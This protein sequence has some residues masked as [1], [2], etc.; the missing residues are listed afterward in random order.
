[1]KKRLIEQTVI[2]FSILK[3]I[4]LAT[5][6]GAIVGVSTTIFLK[7]LHLSIDTT[8]NY[9]LTFL[10][11]PFAFFTSVI[12]TKYLAPDAEG[13]GTEKVIEAIHKNHGKMNIMVVPVKLVSTIISIASGGS[14]G[15]EG[16]CAQIGAGLASTFSDIFRF[17]NDDRKKLVIC[18]ISAG[19]SAVFGTPIAGAIFGVEVLV[20]GNILYDV[21]LPSFVS[22]IVAFQVSVL[23]GIE[24]FYHPI[25][26]ASS[27][28]RVLFLNVLL[29]GVFF[30]LCAF[31]LIESLKL[32]KTLSAKI[33]LWMPFKGII[34]GIL[35]IILSLI[36]SKQFLGLGVETI[37]STLVG[38]KVIWYAFLMKII[39][40]S[41][42][43]NFGGSGGILTP[44]FFIG[45]TAG[46]FFA[47][48][49]NLD[50]SI[51]ASIGLV[52]LLAGAAN[53]PIAASIMAVEI[54]GSR[55]APY[56]AIACIISFLM[57]GHR[58][59]YHSQ[60]ITVK[61]ARSL[62]MELGQEVD[63]I[64]ITH[65]LEQI[66]ESKIKSFL[67]SRFKKNKK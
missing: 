13:H 31:L 36:F 12:I 60:M 17:N 45:T 34:G 4:I 6:V 5:F 66:T 67:I 48:V 49:M 7:L 23:L 46:V 61:K 24:H 44:I 2:F 1:M 63:G 54:F 33:P 38:N 56:A 55:I 58:S 35:L 65:S 32:F 52:G 25:E 41:I 28:D 40:T 59:V 22:G 9:S 10:F 3:W 43:L 62:G 37:E 14:A 47:D 20:I 42:T 29:S 26:I 18:G 64:K 15:K 11:L 30:G 21:L 8:N 19:F 39:F 27:F 53:T 57:T 50:R 51:F 16:P